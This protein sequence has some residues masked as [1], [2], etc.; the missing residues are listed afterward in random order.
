MAQP[1]LK[2]KA[3][4]EPISEKELSDIRRDRLKLVTLNQQVYE[5]NLELGKTPAAKRLGEL[6]LEVATL[7]ASLTAREENVIARLKLKA[8]IIGKIKAIIQT[9]EGQCRPKWKEAFLALATRMKLNATVEEARV[10]S[11]TVIPKEY[12]LVIQ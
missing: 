11:E 8:K 7:Q 5:A 9:I 3:E 4:K 2:L 6:S 1:A 12:R 10:K